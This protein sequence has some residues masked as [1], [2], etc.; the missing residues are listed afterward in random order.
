ME[1]AKLKE[2]L[3]EA[4]VVGAGGAGFP[5]YAKLS[6]KADTVILNCAECEPLLKVHRQV[7]SEYAYEILSALSEILRA[8]GAEKAVVAV[9]AHYN[10]AIEALEE[11]IAEFPNISIFKLRS[12][13]PSGDEILLIKEV[14]GR[15]V[16][17][18]NL[19]ITVGV[20]VC[21]VES[22]YNVYKAMQGQPVTDKFVTVAGEVKTPVTV[23]APIGT[24]IKALIEYAGGATVDDYEV[25]S[26]GPMMGQIVNETFVVTKTTN[27]VIILPKNHNIILNKK[28]S[29]IINLKR[30]MAVCCQ[31][32]TCT[33]LCSRHVAGYPVEP[34]MVMRVLASG[35]KGDL[36]AIAGSLFCSGCGLCENYSCPQSLSPRMMIAQLKSAARN[37]GFKF[38]D[39]LKIYEDVKDSEFK[40]VSVQRLTS[41]LG[42][43]KYDVP[44]PMDSGF[45][46]G[47]VKV[48]IL[49]NIGA[50]PVPTVKEGDEVKKGDMIAKAFEG[51]LSVNVHA[52]VSGKVTRVTDA[53]IK[54]N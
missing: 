11:E 18:G 21:N 35:G 2:L 1:L 51:A 47:T 15:M 54:I 7:L 27:A 34:H 16:R 4:G 19:P 23:C 6:E 40:K 52:S 13:Y 44:A 36:N 9:K 3:R 28:R 49:P 31:C 25:I 14:T 22:V 33:E 41:R 50:K 39:D 37:N 5:T 8:T 30:T 48:S 32:R 43:K 45:S 53:Y 10:E 29:P 42:L 38:P 17:P 24:P 26:G 20:T 12:V 46:A